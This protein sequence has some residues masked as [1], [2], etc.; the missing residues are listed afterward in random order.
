MS[1]VVVSE[2][3]TR[4]GGCCRV[5]RLPSPVSES[6]GVEV[7]ELGVSTAGRWI[8]REG[9]VNRL[10]PPFRKGEEVLYKDWF[11]GPLVGH[12]ESS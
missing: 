9:K 1:S 6:W 2:S 5:V 7:R 3:R 11:R 10:P 12:G 4:V 8:L